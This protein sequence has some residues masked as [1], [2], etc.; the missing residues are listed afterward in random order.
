[1]T[2]A[3]TP[4]QIAVLAAVHRG[5]EEEGGLSVDQLEPDEGE[6][7]AVLLSRGL[8]ETIGEDEG[9]IVARITEEGVST[10]R[11]LGYRR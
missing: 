6:A 2:L 11:D 8:V 9:E 4:T 1:M 3:L 5:D 10:L 7:L